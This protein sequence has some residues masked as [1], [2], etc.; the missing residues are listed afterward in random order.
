[1]QLFSAD[2]PSSGKE[3]VVSLLVNVYT[4]HPETHQMQEVEQDTGQGGEGDRTLAGFEHCRH[5][6]WG[7]RAVRSLGCILLPSLATQN[8]YAQ[9]ADLTQL[10][11]E[12]DLIISHLPTIA[13]ATGFLEDFIRFRTENIAEAVRQAST[14]E[15]GMVVI[16]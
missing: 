8:V 12:C 1:M 4:L 16:W 15:H 9:G 2:R 14:L 11:A 6:L 10:A 7:A 13:A 3:D 5:E